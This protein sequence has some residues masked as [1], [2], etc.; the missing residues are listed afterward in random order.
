MT[1][2]FDQQKVTITIRGKEFNTGETSQ[3]SWDITGLYTLHKSGGGF[4][5]ERQGELIVYPPGFDPNK[6][7]LSLPEKTFQ[8]L[9]QKKFGRVLT[10]KFEV[11]GKA[12][13]IT[14]RIEADKGWLVLGMV[15]DKKK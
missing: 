7:K 6:N 10:E 1:V 8:R 12:D 9:L 4:V 2:H 5:A 14:K 15:L 3:G 11:T 13:L